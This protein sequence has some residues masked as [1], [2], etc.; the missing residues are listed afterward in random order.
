MRKIK[1]F[2]KDL[3][4]IKKSILINLGGITLLSIV[5]VKLLMWS[6]NYYTLHNESIE[7]PDLVNL[8]VEEAIKLLE[9]RKLNYIVVDSIC[10]GK[11]L[12][13]VIKH[14]NP[15][16]TKQ[17]KESRKIYLTIT[18]YA[19][20][21]V[22]LYYD[23]LIG[24]D[25]SYVVRY[26]ERSNLKVGKLTY[27][28]G[29]K[30]KNTVVEAFCNGAPLFIEANARSG[31]KPPTEPK[32]VKQNAVIDLVL[33]KGE[34]ANPKFI[35]DLMCDNYD[36]AE[37][38]IKTS[39]FNLGTINTSGPITDTLSAWIYNQNPAPGEIAS[40]G[41]GIDLWLVQEFPEACKETDEIKN[42]PEKI[43]Q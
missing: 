11:G 16:P 1:V 34:G 23:R 43:Q 37:F 35:P 2:F 13:G 21:T 38:T 17:V 14:Q 39:Q 33:L 29:G 36:A 7:T 28:N 6:L 12:G 42:I 27:K 20:C 19:E 3:W 10:R 15:R 30:A 4:F 5:L 25:R 40:M 18:S 32:K 22:N 31:E 41:R 8:K 9:A 24:R 26:L